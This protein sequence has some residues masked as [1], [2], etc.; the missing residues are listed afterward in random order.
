MNGQRCNNSAHFTSFT[1]GTAVYQQWVKAF[2]L[3]CPLGLY[4]PTWI[5]FPSIPLEYFKLA[6]RAAGM[7]GKIMG[8]DFTGTHRE[9]P[10]FCVGLDISQGW[11][12][13]VT[14]HSMAGGSAIIPIE[15][16]AMIPRYS[17]CGNH[18]HPST[19]CNQT[20]WRAGGQAVA[21]RETL[22]RC[23]GPQLLLLALGNGRMTRLDPMLGKTGSSIG[24]AQRQAKHP[25]PQPSPD[26]EGFIPVVHKRN[27]QPRVNRPHNQHPRCSAPYSRAHA[28]RD[29]QQDQHQPQTRPTS[30]HMAPAQP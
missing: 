12:S 27:R 13:S 23:H 4:T 25:R 15:Y 24:P 2:N 20:A 10:H 28:R 1:G 19:L 8:E 9:A 6:R 11:I 14:V 26:V 30:Q 29:D 22:P 18:F 21:S 17:M 7:L 5:S 16:E 3:Q